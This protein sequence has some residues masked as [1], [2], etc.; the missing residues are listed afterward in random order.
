MASQVKDLVLSL[1]WLG[2]LLWLW[3]QSLTWKLSHDMGVAKKPNQNKTKNHL[4]CQPLGL[5]EVGPLFHKI[6][7]H[8]LTAVMTSQ[9]L[10]SWSVFIPHSFGWCPMKQLPELSSPAHL[11]CTSVTWT[12]LSWPP[13]SAPGRSRG[14]MDTMRSVC[15]RAACAGSAAAS[16]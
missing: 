7:L 1:L 14:C 13:R 2:L 9:L 8:M 5:T 16:S 12:R 3:V 10:W 11:Q 15:G 4:K 6:S